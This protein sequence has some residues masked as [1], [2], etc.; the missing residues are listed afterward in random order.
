MK[1][2]LKE[3]KIEIDDRNEGEKYSTVTKRNM[4]TKPTTRQTDKQDFGHEISMKVN[5][6]QC[7]M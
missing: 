3:K 5:Y 4:M 2:K 6:H 1:K 7:S